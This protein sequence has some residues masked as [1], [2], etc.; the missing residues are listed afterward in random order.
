MMFNYRSYPLLRLPNSR[1]GVPCLLEFVSA[2]TLYSSSVGSVTVDLF[3][4]SASLQA[5]YFSTSFTVT[6][7]TSFPE[8]S[9][10][11]TRGLQKYV[12]EWRENF[13]LWMKTL[14]TYPN[15]L[16]RSITVSSGSRGLTVIG[17]CNIITRLIAYIITKF[18]SIKILIT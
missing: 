1:K 11:T 5:M 2:K 7:P 14:R 16:K 9:M 3:A 8:C 17:V 15:F 4:A 6:N 18:D 13:K 10:S 12:S